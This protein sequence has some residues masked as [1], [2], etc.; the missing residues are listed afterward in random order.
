MN[1]VNAVI[2]SASAIVALFVALA[3]GVRI[4]R[5]SNATKGLTEMEI[6]R[7]ALEAL[8]KEH[9]EQADDIEAL[10]KYQRAMEHTRA[11]DI[12]H[13]EEQAR[14]QRGLINHIDD[15]H[16][17]FRDGANPPPPAISPTLA[18]ILGRDI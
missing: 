15:W 11:E 13:R 10:K 2:G 1:D 3:G 5:K 8:R 12:R 6:L 18:K 4:W 9:N 14:I 16:K 17:W 7:Q